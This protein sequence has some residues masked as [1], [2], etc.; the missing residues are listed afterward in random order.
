VLTSQSA[1]GPLSTR[2]VLMGFG[3][4]LIAKDFAWVVFVFSPLTVRFGPSRFW[5]SHHALPQLQPYEIALNAGHSRLS[6]VLGTRRAQENTSSKL[7]DGR[8]R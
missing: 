8:R 4:R 5:E 7:G 3:W 6:R 2:G 1:F